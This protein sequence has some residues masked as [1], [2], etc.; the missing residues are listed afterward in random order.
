VYTVLTSRDADEA[1]AAL[2]RLPPALRA[3]LSRLSPM[4]YLDDIRAPLIV[5]GHDRNDQVIPV[6]ESRTLHTALAGRPGVRYTE[7]GMFQHMDPT[8]SKLPPQ[9]LAQE[10]GRFYAYAYPMFRQAMA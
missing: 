5:I 2:D 9:R 4:N 10:L 8:Q 6:G 1:Q 3:R 7:F